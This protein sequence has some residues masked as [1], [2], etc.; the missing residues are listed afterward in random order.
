MRKHIK[1]RKYH[2]KTE[3]VSIM[4]VFFVFM[5]S[6]EILCESI[7]TISLW[8]CCIFG[9][10]VFIAREYTMYKAMHYSNT[11]SVY[12]YFFVLFNI[13]ILFDFNGL[14]Q[15]DNMCLNKHKVTIYN[16]P[17]NK[18]QHSRKTL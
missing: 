17:Q 16:Y 5:K 12:L 18:Y 8:Y 10:C 11:G 2:Y 13:L 1:V 9:C 15:F 3:K 4:S 6:Q 7:F 14:L